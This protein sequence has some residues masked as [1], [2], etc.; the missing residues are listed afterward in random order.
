MDIVWDFSCKW[1]FNFNYDKSAV[2]I[3]QHHNVKKFP[4]RTIWKLGTTILEEVNVYKYLG[5]EFDQGLTFREFKDRI[6]DK[7]RRGNL[8]AWSRKMR[9]ANLSVKA[10]VNVW[11]VMVRPNL[12]YGAAV[13]GFGGWEEAEVLQRETGRKILGVPTQAVK[14][15][16]RGELGWWTMTAR[17]DEIRMRFWIRLLLLN[18]DRLVKEVYLM[19]KRNWVKEKKKNWASEVHTLAIKYNLRELWEDEET[20]Y[21]VPVE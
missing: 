20:V 1:R 10:N 7:A 15:A 18:E 9:E 21:D 12:E 11:D 13:W 3:F 8:I 19:S 2:L 17:R 6:A 5:I 16:I 4:D 14:E